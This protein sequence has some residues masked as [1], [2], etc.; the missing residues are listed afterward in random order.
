VLRRAIE[1][2]EPLVQEISDSGLLIDRL[3]EP[4]RI[5]Q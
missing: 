4:C 2:S 1:G 5:R 3:P